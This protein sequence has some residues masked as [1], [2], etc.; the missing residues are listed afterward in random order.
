MNESI[1]M[2]VQTRTTKTLGVKAG[3]RAGNNVPPKQDNGA[4]P[5]GGGGKG[6]RDPG[7]GDGDGLP[8]GA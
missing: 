5:P 7:D 4:A 8:I 2:L 6:P 3:I 1:K